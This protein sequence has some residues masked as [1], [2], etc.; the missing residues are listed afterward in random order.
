[1]KKLLFYLTMLS[2]A[3]AINSCEKETFEPDNFAKTI[4]FKDGLFHT[5]TFTVS[6]DKTSY[7][8]GET[9]KAK[10]SL[11]SS[12]KGSAAYVGGVTIAEHYYSLF[13]STDFATCSNP[14]VFIEECPVGTTPSTYS[15]DFEVSRTGALWPTTETKYAQIPYEIK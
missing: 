7:I 12:H 13:N 4:S 10:L 3:I 6:L 15:A 9:A 14:C 11:S 8:V 5:V 1:M 2:M